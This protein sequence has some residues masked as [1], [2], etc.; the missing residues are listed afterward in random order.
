MS[1]GRLFI[2]LL[3]QIGALSF[4]VLRE[5]VEIATLAGHAN[6]GPHAAILRYAPGAHVPAHRHVGFE[7]IYVLK[8]SQRDE[9][10]TYGE[11]SLV[12]NRAG[13]EH[14]VESDEGCIVVIFWEKPVE[15]LSS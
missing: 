9:R 6:G 7:V 2:R 11:G 13:D 4:Q 15:F 10:A 5:G 8:G 1:P 12:V 14:T 3:D